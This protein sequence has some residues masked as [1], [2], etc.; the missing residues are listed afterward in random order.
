[1]RKTLNQ[2]VDIDYI[3][4]VCVFFINV[5]LQKTKSQ[6]EEYLIN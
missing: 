6:L 3:V 4:C 2:P 5:G 1:M